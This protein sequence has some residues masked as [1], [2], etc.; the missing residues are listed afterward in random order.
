MT[1]QTIWYNENGAYAY[2]YY[3][4]KNKICKA[5]YLF[6]RKNIQDKKKNV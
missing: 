2:C 4:N 1:K 5:Q 3:N 6:N